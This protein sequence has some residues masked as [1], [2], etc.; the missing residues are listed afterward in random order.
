[1]LTKWAADAP[2]PD[3][4]IAAAMLEKPKELDRL[5]RYITT[6][7]RAFYRAMDKLA[8]LQKERKE[9]E[10]ANALEQAWVEKVR[11]SELKRAAA[12]EPAAQIG[13]V[14]QSAAPPQ[15]PVAQAA[16]PVRAIAPVMP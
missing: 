6:H 1:V 2:D 11:Q 3:A 7:E 13:F 15:T 8:K 12:P 9:A 4:A 16:P 5:I 14:S 10:R